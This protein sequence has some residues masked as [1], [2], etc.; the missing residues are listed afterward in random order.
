MTDDKDVVF[1]FV[2]MSDKTITN[3]DTMEKRQLTTEEADEI[4]AKLI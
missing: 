2:N 3:V 4:K 1:E